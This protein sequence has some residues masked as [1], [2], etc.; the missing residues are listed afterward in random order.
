MP[1]KSALRHKNLENIKKKKNTRICIQD[2]GIIS[3]SVRKGEE[4]DEMYSR[5]VLLSGFYGKA[6][7]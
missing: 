5:E 3:L 4:T 2:I 1:C 7:I 6:L